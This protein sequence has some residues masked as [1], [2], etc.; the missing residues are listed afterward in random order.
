VGWVKSLRNSI[1]RNRLRRVA[2]TRLIVSS[3]KALRND[4]TL[5]TVKARF[6][7]DWSTDEKAKVL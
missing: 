2:S 4:K 5:E 6:F 1:S 3:I 7:Q